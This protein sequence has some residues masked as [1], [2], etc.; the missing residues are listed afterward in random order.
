[1]DPAPPDQPLDSRAVTLWRVQRLI[2]L[3]LF[4]L[5][6]AVAVGG[7]LSTVIGV[8]AGVAIGGGLLSLSVLLL[9]AWPPLEYRHWRYAVR[10]HDLLVQHGVLFRRWSS[11][12]LNRIQHVDTRQGPLERMLGL[13]RLLVYTASGVSADGSIPG[14]AQ[15]VAEQLRDELS[16]RGGDDG[17]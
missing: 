16:R 10:E 6:F 2:R 14:L 13:S 7:G 4:N 12:P 9:L 3:A 1:M 17:V 11:I 15:P 5:P 8:G